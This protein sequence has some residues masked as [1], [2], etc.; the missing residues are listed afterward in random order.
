MIDREFAMASSE[1]PPDGQRHQRLSELLKYARR[2]IPSDAAKL[3]NSE[4]VPGRIGK[5][6]SQEE[7]AEVVGVS[8]VWYSLLESGRPVQA[9]ISLLGR[10]CAALTLDEQQRRD[11]FYYGATEVCLAIASTTLHSGTHGGATAFPARSGP[12][13]KTSRNRQTFAGG[14]AVSAT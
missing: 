8:R 13:T 11:L 4:R 14:S 12:V 7:I 1:E 3:G 2:S 10:I 6:V 9:S 5:L